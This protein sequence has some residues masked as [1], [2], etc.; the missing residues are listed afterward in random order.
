MHQ[1]IYYC[2]NNNNKKNNKNNNNNDNTS[3]KL[4]KSIFNYS[5][6]DFRYFQNYRE[7][8]TNGII[9]AV[10]W[11]IGPIILIIS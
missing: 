1:I 11:L 7:A 4:R 10:K 8:S 3:L 6:G 5:L 9:I 2:N